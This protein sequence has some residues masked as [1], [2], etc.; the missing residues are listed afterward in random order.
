LSTAAPSPVPEQEYTEIRGDLRAL[1]GVM[2]QSARLLWRCAPVMYLC[3]CLVTV[4]DGFTPVVVVWVGKQ[5]LDAIVAAVR[6]GADAGALRGLFAVLAMQGTILLS[7]MA[8]GR[9]GTFARSYIGVKLSLMLESEITE[10]AARIDLLQ[11]EDSR[12]H[13]MISR[14]MG[15]AG[16][17]PLDLVDKVAGLVG[18]GITFAAMGAMIASFSAA[19]FASMLVIC[20]PYLI[21]QIRFGREYFLTRQR[22]THDARMASR[23][24]GEMMRRE[25][26]AEI[27]S[28]NLSG[29]LFGKW[30]AFTERFVTEDMRLN[31]RRISIEA[32]MEGIVIVARAVAL[33]YIAYLGL[34][35]V[36]GITPGEVVMYAGAF[37]GG[38]RGRGQRLGQN[39]GHVPGI[40]VLP[41]PPGVL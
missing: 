39:I 19:L 38:R 27:R 31:R 23:L 25:S 8:V 6:F 3:V 1:A 28:Y 32:F 12:V 36:G 33:G 13:D 5:V 26:A 30:R 2:Y 22:R 21:M 35:R 15:E 7:F 41:E 24:G 16:A 4:A 37:G 34:R 9:L 14:A 40:A 18:A 11:F 29:F 10:R 20:V 17:K